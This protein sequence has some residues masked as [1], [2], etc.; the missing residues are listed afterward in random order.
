MQI[1]P[2]TVSSQRNTPAG[3]L[4][5]CDHRHNFGVPMFQSTIQHA[6][7][8]FRAKSNH[9]IMR[10]SLD[11]DYK[12]I[13]TVT[14]AKGIV[15]FCQFFNYIRNRQQTFISTLMSIIVIKFFKI[16]FLVTIS[17]SDHA[18]YNFLEA[19]N[20]TSKL[21]TL[22]SIPSIPLQKAV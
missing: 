18:P 9:L 19:P 6:L 8:Q 10:N 7:T 16:F 17:F 1:I 11:N 20:S 5:N 2:H 15:L 12:L 21:A 22:S 13:S 4:R 3:P 14:C